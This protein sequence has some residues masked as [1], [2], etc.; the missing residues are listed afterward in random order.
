MIQKEYMYLVYIW[1]KDI[2]KER[3]GVLVSATYPD[4]I[5]NVIRSWDFFE[6]VTLRIPDYD[7]FDYE[8]YQYNDEYFVNMLAHKISKGYYEL[9]DR[10]VNTI[11]H[12]DEIVTIKDNSFIEYSIGIEK[13][14]LV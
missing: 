14:E 11:S 4:K 12:Y 2:E 3:T 5:K 6:N 9:C 13:Y 8:C 10:P 7:S 1:N